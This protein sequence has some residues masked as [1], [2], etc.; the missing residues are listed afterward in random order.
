MRKLKN[1]FRKVE[2]IW[3]TN[4]CSMCKGTIK[5]LEEYGLAKEKVILICPDFNCF[6]N[7]TGHHISVVSIESGLKVLRD[8]GTAM[9]K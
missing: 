5:D 9:T 8:V 2:G 6:G 7:I 1:L 4:N 3:I